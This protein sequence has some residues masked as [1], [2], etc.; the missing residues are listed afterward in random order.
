MST[1]RKTLDLDQTAYDM[2]CGSFAHCKSCP[3]WVHCP[4]HCEPYPGYDAAC[5]Q[6]TD[7]H[8]GCLRKAQRGESVQFGRELMLDPIVPFQGFAKEG[9]LCAM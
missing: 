2:A 1:S 3:G 6:W 4:A 8:K 5:S 7:L 9:E